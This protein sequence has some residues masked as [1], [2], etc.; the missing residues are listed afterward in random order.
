MHF[1]RFLSFSLYVI[2]YRGRLAAQSQIVT[3]LI[4]AVSDLTSNQR[5]Y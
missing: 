2:L 5:A 4:L 1:M 3:G